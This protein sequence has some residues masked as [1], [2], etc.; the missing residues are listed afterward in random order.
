[1]KKQLSYPVLSLLLALASGPAWASPV[2]NCTM[3]ADRGI[4]AVYGELSRRAIEIVTR[5][6]ADG[7]KND[8]KLLALVAPDAAFGLGSGD[9]GRPFGTGLGG[10][11]TLAR[12]MK[13]DSYR[14]F[15]W[16]SIPSQVD[17]CGE[18]KVRVEFID[19]RSANLADMEF[20]F[21]GGVLISAQ[22]WMRWYVSGQLEPA[23]DS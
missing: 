6:T 19:S 1:V 4:G 18:W 14:Y 22:G 15:T 7:W 21:R 5:A 17:P 23:K 13:A 20:S 8:P 11:R 2:A 9:V 12:E 10:A 16:S 3:P